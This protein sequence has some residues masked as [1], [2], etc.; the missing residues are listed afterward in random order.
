M[1]FDSFVLYL[2]LSCVFGGDDKIWNVLGIN[3]IYKSICWVVHEACKE[4]DTDLGDWTTI[5]VI[6]IGVK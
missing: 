5:Q 1:N 3:S 6:K 2:F 4:L